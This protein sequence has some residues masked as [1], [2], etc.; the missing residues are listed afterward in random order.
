MVA[1]RGKPELVVSDNGSN[2][3]SADRELRDMVRNFDQDQIVEE[4]AA[5]GIKW[6]FNPPWGSHHGGLFETLVKST[7]RALKAL[8]GEAESRKRNSTPR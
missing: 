3:V 7:K 1:R 5:K 4:A 6:R 2:F 8:L